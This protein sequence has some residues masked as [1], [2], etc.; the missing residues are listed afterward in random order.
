VKNEIVI[1]VSD[2]IVFS[3]NGEAGK[4][5]TET[6]FDDTSDVINHVLTLVPAEMLDGSSDLEIR[7]YAHPSH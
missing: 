4:A 1:L 3:I 2:D 6:V 5:L 7:L